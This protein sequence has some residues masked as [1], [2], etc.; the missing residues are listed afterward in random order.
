MIVKPP[1]RLLAAV[2]CLWLT[3]G[4]TQPP[5]ATSGSSPEKPR[6]ETELSRTTITREARKS[7][8]L[9]TT[10]VRVEAVQEHRTLSGWIMVPPDMEGPV[11]APVHGYVRAPSGK[12]VTPAPG[13]P[14][15]LGQEL[16]RLEPVLLPLEYTQLAALRRGIEG[17]LEKAQEDV[18]VAKNEL[19]RIEN[20]HKQKLRGDRDVEQ[21]RASLK[22]AQADLN[23]AEDKL[24]YI[25]APGT[26]KGTFRPPIQSILAPRAGI[27]L[28][29]PVAPGQFVAQAA[30]LVIIADLSKPWVRVPVPEFDLPRVDRG[31]DAQVTVTP[32]GPGGKAAPQTIKAHPVAL[33]PQVDPLRHTADLM[34]QLDP[35]TENAMLAKDQMVTVAVPLGTR[36]K[37]SIV[38][39][40]AILFDAYGGSWVYIDRTPG[41]AEQCIYERVRVDLGPPARDNDVVVRPALKAGD[42]VVSEGAAA[43]FSREF[44]RP[45][46]VVPE[47]PKKDKK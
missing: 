8:G 33:V 37:E 7:L 2:A 26:E 4:C 45:P 28:T 13:Q 43:L 17:D 24:K 11:T 44:Y 14:V 9:K 41:D 10:P 31:R 15:R 46:V 29:V 5:A 39:Y 23:A 6:A 34:Y 30:P 27:A 36:A 22:K 38:P 19:E 42:P 40:A 3:S 20:L 16:F 47:A 18:S 35:P 21:A 12:A 25:S 32:E 1:R